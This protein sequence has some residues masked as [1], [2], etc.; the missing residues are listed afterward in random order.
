MPGFLSIKTQQQEE[1]KPK[2]KKKRKVKNKEK[3]GEKSPNLE[4]ID[5]DEPTYCLCEQ[6][7]TSSSTRQKIHRFRLSYYRPVTRAGNSD[8]CLSVRGGGRVCLVWEGPVGGGGTRVH[9]KSA[10]WALPVQE[11][12]WLP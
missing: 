9:P 8:R 4:P 5:P 3:G 12:G 6:V 10:A 1:D 7:G 2:K 11:S